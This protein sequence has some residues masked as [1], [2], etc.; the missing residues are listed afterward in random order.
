MGSQRVRHSC[1]TNAFSPPIS[2]QTTKIR[3]WEL[4]EGRKQ[5]S[6][7]QSFAGSPFWTRGWVL[8]TMGSDED[9][10]VSALSQKVAGCYGAHRA[11]TQSWPV[12][13]GKN[14]RGVEKG[15]WLGGRYIGRH[16]TRNSDKCPGKTP[17]GMPPGILISAQ[18]RHQ[19]AVMCATFSVLTPFWGNQQFIFLP[20][21]DLFHWGAK[22]YLLHHT[23]KMYVN[24]HLSR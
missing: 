5:I 11:G 24:K 20:G 9:W 10:A 8:S 13:L 3:H 21:N 17:G 16:A 19:V 7:I 22:K 4:H 18:E 6:I 23:A 1:V 14:P 2:K 12:C 15:W